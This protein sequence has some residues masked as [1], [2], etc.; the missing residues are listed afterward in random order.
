[1]PCV[2]DGEAGAAN[3]RFRIVD[4]G[5]QNYFLILNDWLIRINRPF[6]IKNLLF[7]AQAKNIVL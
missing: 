5:F 6:K 3:F 7:F 1:M 4:C 2:A